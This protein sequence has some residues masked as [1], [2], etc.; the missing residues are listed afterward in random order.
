MEIS[1]GERLELY[2]EKCGAK[3]EGYAAFCPECGARIDYDEKKV[4]TPVEK[5]SLPI[6][7]IVAVALGVCLVGA[8]GFILYQNNAINGLK[9]NDPVTQ[10]ETQDQNSNIAENYV[11]SVTDD[12]QTSVTSDGY[13]DVDVEYKSENT[14]EDYGINPN[15]VEDYSNNLDLSDFELFYSGIGG[16]YNFRYPTKLF[17]NLTI[18]E[19]SYSSVFGNNHISYNFSGS[20]GS[21]MN[22]MVFDRTDNKSLTEMGCLQRLRNRSA[23]ESVHLRIPECRLLLMELMMVIRQKE[24]IN[25]RI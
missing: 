22:F 19:S 10:A 7:K 18:D 4:S 12:S 16:A 11:D 2:C 15:L 17:N 13:P 9:D 5:R 1:K 21:K 25:R 3:I 8:I 20:K 23:K 6:T 14:N 24:K